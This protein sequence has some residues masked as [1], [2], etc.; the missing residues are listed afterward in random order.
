[1][2]TDRTPRI[3]ELHVAIGHGPCERVEDAFA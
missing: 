2:P 1:L 3:Q